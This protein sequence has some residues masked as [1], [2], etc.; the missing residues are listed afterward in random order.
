M[1]AGSGRPSRGA[2]RWAG[3]VGAILLGGTTAACSSVPG[4]GDGRSVEKY[5][6][7]MEKHKD[8]YETAMAEASASDDFLTGGAQALSALGDLNQ[9]WSELSDVAPDEI[10][11]PVAAAAGRVATAAVITFPTP[12]IQQTSRD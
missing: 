8:R 2:F 10:R 7:V 3:C 11:V 9:M 12:Q 1:R 5:C 4:I 6:A